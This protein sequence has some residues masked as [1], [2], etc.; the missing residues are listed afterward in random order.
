MSKDLKVHAYSIN[1]RP[2]GF[3]PSL[4][5]IG[6]S[7]DFV[8]VF[9]LFL[10]YLPLEKGMVL[11]LDKLE[12]PSPK[13]D[14][15]RDW[16]KLTQWFWRKWFLNFVN[17]FS[18]FVIFSPWKRA[19]PFIWTNLNSLHL[20]ILCAL[21]GWNWHCGSGKEDFK[22]S[23]S[24]FLH[25]V[26]ISHWKRAWLFIWTNLNSLWIGLV[27]LERKILYFVNTFSIF[28]Y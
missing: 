17:V 2:M 25:F 9:S 5:E 15:C 7:G 1:K 16:L 3:L 10:N 13:D 12:F 23:S 14:L 21:F 20:R 18:L 26:I 24:Y 4:A 11:H 6:G 8:N 28:R 27:V 19:W 22:I